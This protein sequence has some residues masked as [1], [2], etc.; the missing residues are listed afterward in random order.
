LTLV[1]KQCIIF[2]NLLVNFLNMEP[3]KSILKEELQNSLNLKKQ[4]EKELKKLPKGVLVRK[5]IKGHI[6]YYLVKRERHKVKYYYK[7]KLN[8]D[9]V[10][11]FLKIKNLRRK[12]KFLI[13][14]LNKQIKFLK[15]SLKSGKKTD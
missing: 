13:H 2:I 5:T 1:T 10:R 4:Y 7:G 11:E 9:E 14:E 6:Y 12:Y 3:I 15:K 8:R